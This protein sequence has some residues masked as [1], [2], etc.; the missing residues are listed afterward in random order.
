MSADRQYNLKSNNQL[1]SLPFELQAVSP[2]DF[3][4]DFAPD[5]DFDS[6]SDFSSLLHLPSHHPSPPPQPLPPKVSFVSSPVQFGNDLLPSSLLFHLG[7]KVLF[8]RMM[9]CILGIWD[10]CGVYKCCSSIRECVRRLRSAFSRYLADVT[11]NHHFR[12]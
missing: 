4:F 1:Y 11:H 8:R 5:S 12:I 6:D 10:L 3:D 2:A 9:L 7:R